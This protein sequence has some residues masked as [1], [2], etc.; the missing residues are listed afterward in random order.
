MQ[1]EERTQPFNVLRT[2]FIQVAVLDM[3]WSHAVSQS[4]TFPRKPLSY[5]NDSY[6]FFGA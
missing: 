1:M 2:F 3:S 5:L 4:D 6:L